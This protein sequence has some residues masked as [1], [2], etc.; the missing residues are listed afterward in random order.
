MIE[1]GLAY[2]TNFRAAYGRKRIQVPIINGY[3]SCGR[4]WIILG[5]YKWPRY[6]SRN[7]TDKR[8]PDIPSSIGMVA[9]NTLDPQTFGRLRPFLGDSTERYGIR[10]T[11]Y[12]TI[13]TEAPT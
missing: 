5:E 8:W 11:A 3:G 7:R 2:V 4:R 12:H 10:V 6:C 13:Q 9:A 1:P